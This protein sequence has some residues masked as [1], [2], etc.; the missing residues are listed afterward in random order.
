[1]S[2]YVI[3]GERQRPRGQ[4]DPSPPS[5]L[6][7]FPPR[8]R[9]SLPVHAVPI[10]ASGETLWYWSADKEFAAVVGHVTLTPGEA[11]VF[12]E[13][14]S[15]TGVTGPVVLTAELTSSNLP[16]TGGGSRAVIFGAQTA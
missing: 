1:M 13:R 4:Q 8:S 12:E 15:P 16:E 6:T 14:W 7:S 11:I 3:P 2:G 5:P 10:A 9:G